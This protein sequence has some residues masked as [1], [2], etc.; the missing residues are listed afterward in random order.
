MSHF[1]NYQNVSQFYENTRTAVGVDIIRNHLENGEL[2]INKQLLVDAG[3]GTGLYSAALVNHVRKIE[4]ID[5]NAGMLKIGKEK[6]KSEEKKGLINFYISSIDSLPLDNDSVDAVMVNQVLHHLPDNST[7]GWAHHEKVFR[8]F[9]RVLKSGGMLIINSCSPEQIEC[10]FW[11]YNLIPEAKEK[12]TQKVI[13]L[14]DLNNLL[15]HCG[16]SN[17]VQEVNMDLVLQSD[18]YFNSGGIFNADWRSGDSIWS[19][20]P[21][22]ILSEVLIKATKM[23]KEGELE[24]YLKHHD[25]NR[26]TTGQVTFSISKK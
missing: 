13:N 22:K 10:G 8:E 9:W 25:Q 20:V 3:C 15:K 24:S 11:F 21:E 5:L 1:E 2:P 18:A 19:L 14:S 26:K 16:F 23:H 6:M 12:M 4:A 7:G 17:T